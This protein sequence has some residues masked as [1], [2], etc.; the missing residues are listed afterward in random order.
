MEKLIVDFAKLGDDLGVPGRVLPGPGGKGQVKL[1]DWTPE[2]SRK[3]METV[4]ERCKSE[5]V[6]ELVVAGMSPCV[7]VGSL[8]YAPAER[9]YYAVPQGEIEMTKLSRGEPDPDIDLRIDIR[10][11]GDTVYM[12]AAFDRP[13]SKMHTFDMKDLPKVVIPHIPE[14]RRVLFRGI[15]GAPF[16]ALT[17][18]QLLDDKPLSI[19]WAFHAGDKDFTCIYTRTPDAAFGEV[20]TIDA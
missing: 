13:G 8:I 1:H 17:I 18:W 16:Q 6:K 19:H 12:T 10:E 14:N 5:N 9:K 7:Q 4:V 20:I 2:T 15:G 3:A 11:D